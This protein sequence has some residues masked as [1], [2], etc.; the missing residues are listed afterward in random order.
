[1]SVSLVLPTS[2][3]S[4][5]PCAACKLR[6]NLL[7]LPPSLHYQKIGRALVVLPSQHLP[8][9]LP[10]SQDSSRLDRRLSLL[11]DWHM[12]ASL[13][14]LIIIIFFFFL[15]LFSRAFSDACFVAPC[16]SPS[17][18]L[19]MLHCSFLHGASQCFS[20]SF[21]GLRFFM[22]SH[23]A[24]PSCCLLGSSRK[25]HHGPSLCSARSFVVAIRGP[26]WWQ[27]EVYITGLMAKQ[28]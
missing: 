11:Y 7:V 18:F 9:L 19:M 14:I 8:L 12:P 10:P 25:F 16:S 1:M 3:C 6:E 23:G 13:F 2:L 26:P 17:R 27:F 15:L 5:P 21:M 22:V 20:A 28:S 24:S 4:G